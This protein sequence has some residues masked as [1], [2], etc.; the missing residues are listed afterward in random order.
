VSPCA[1]GS[2]A[3]SR[4]NKSKTR[5]RAAVPG[6]QP[7]RG[8]WL[9][10]G[11]GFGDQRADRVGNRPPS[12]LCPGKRYKPG[13]KL[14]GQREARE[15]GLGR[16]VATR[17]RRARRSVHGAEAASSEVEPQDVLAGGEA[18][19][20]GSVQAGHQ[21]EHDAGS[22]GADLLFGEPPEAFGRPSSRGITE[23]D[24]AGWGLGAWPW[25]IKFRR[26]RT[27]GTHSLVHALVLGRRGRPREASMVE[28]L[29]QSSSVP[30]ESGR[31]VTTLLQVTY[32]PSL[33]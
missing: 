26:A 16:V 25:T 31:G 5:A 17:P 30:A 29:S 27:R 24:P 19:R 10:F 4:R 14:C 32:G 2:T 18:D 23:E 21:G 22:T 1:L 20:G 28:S 7:G 13:T 11:H 9:R 3:R 33:R 15:R 12:R 8:R 6:R